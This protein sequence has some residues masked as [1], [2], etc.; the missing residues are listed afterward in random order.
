MIGMHFTRLC[1][2]TKPF[3]ILHH[4]FVEIIAAEYAF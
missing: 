4:V 1:S 3:D 2:V